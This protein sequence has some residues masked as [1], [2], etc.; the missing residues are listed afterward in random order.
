MKKKIIGIVLGSILGGVNITPM[1]FQNLDYTVIISNFIIWIVIGLVLSISNLKF[2]YII[3]GS[4][5]SV[6]ISASS[7]VYIAASSVIGLIW[8]ILWTILSGAVMGFLFEKI[9]GKIE[10]T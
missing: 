7:L 2:N 9:V 6:V 4:I 8:T 10:R 3:Q 5:M 1:L